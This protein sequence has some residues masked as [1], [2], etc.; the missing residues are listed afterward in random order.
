MWFARHFSLL[1][2]LIAAFAP[3]GYAAT[4]DGG[5][6]TWIAALTPAPEINPAWTAVGSCILATALI[7]RH[8]AKF[9]K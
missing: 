4:S 8:S 1:F 9:R 7:L 6:I 5:G 2:L 3:G